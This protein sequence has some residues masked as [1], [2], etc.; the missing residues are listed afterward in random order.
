MRG[1]NSITQAGLERDHD[2]RTNA[3]EYNR[4]TKRQIGIIRAID[5]RKDGKLF[6]LVD[7]PDGFG[8]FRPFGQNKT[9]I[10]IN[11]APLDILLRFG[12]VRVGQIVEIF[13]RGVTEQGQV[14]AHIIGDE[15]QDFVN[16]GKIPE[17][18]FSTASS[19][20]FEPM[21]IV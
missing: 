9:P 4:G 14:G 7:V 16:A 6:V 1:R 8:G 19:L 3:Q 12:G 10:I 20:P 11:D 17:E 5:P 13:Y 21:G 15:Q 2:N 18:G